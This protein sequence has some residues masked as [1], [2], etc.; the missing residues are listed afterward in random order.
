MG[1]LELCVEEK[2]VIVWEGFLAVDMAGTRY[3]ALDDLTIPSL[4]CIRG[5]WQFRP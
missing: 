2:R 4:L 5:A 1:S 3:K